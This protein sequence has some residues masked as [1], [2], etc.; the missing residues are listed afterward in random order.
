MANQERWRDILTKECGLEIPI[1]RQQ[2][3]ISCPFHEDN[4]PSLSINL[5]KEVFF[6]HAGCGQGSLRSLVLRL[7]SKHL[8][9]GPSLIEED[10]VLF[11]DEDKKVKQVLTELEGMS[12]P[13]SRRNIPKWVK[14]RGFSDAIMRQ[15]DFRISDSGALVIPVYDRFEK[16]V[17]WICRQPNGQNPKY[18]YSKGFSKSQVLFGENHVVKDSRDYVCLVEGS[19]D[20]IWLW[21]H[22]TPAV[23][24]LGSSLSGNQIELLKHFRKFEYVLCFD[25]DEA[26]RKITQQTDAAIK[27]FADVSYIDLTGYK[28]VQE[29]RNGAE[30]VSRIEGRGMIRWG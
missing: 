9:L 15:W 17:G 24:V 14:D 19:L 1:S 28:D 10:F 11:K 12:V 23:A 26:G 5:A 25:N 2:F 27:T 13:F 3:N 20:C 16:T 21:Q 6:C 4:L 29:I 18:V 30:L 8:F 7:T 22:D